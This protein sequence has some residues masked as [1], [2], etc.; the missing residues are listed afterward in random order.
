MGA[1]V[2][3]WKPPSLESTVGK[4]VAVAEVLGPKEIAGPVRRK[5]LA[6]APSDAGRQIEALAPESLAQHETI[7]LVSGTDE[8]NDLALASVARQEDVD[9]VLR[10]QVLSRRSHQEDQDEFDSAAPLAVSWRLMSVADGRHAGGRPVVVDLE[11]ARKDYPELALIADPAEA[12]A[13]AA[14][15]EAYRLVAPSVVRERVQIEIPYLWA[16]S[17][18]VRRG[19]LLARNG[20]WGEAEQVWQKVFDQHP[21]QTAALHNLA[22]AAAAAQD[23]SLAKERIRRVIRRQP[24]PLHKQSM[25]WIEQQQRKYHQ[26]FDL[27]DPPEGWFVTR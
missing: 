6:L 19:N 16:G 27:P 14:A 21:T 24:T 12:L 9:Y 22:I 11:T 23:F 8:V 18:E 26:A 10:G 7:R 5:M 4:R 25:A 13:T 15:R 3:L 20:K 1:P 17:K 2:H